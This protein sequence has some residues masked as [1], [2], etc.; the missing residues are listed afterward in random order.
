MKKTKHLLALILMLTVLLSGC[1]LFGSEPTQ[2]AQPQTSTSTEPTVTEPA[3]TES[4]PTELTPAETEPAEPEPTEPEGELFSVTREGHYIFEE[5]SYD[6]GCVQG[7]PTGVFTIVDRAQDDE[8]L[9]WGK[10]KS[11]M[12]W[13][14]LTE[15]EQA[16]Q[17]ALPVA[18]VEAYP[19]LLKG[20]NADS[21]ELF[22]EEYCYKMAFFAYEKLTDVKLS[23]IDIIS[24]E[25]A[26]KEL[27]WERENLTP[28]RPVMLHLTFPGN[29]TTY[30]LSFLDESGEAR[31]FHIMQ[32]GRNGL[33]YT[34]EVVE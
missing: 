8:G 24:E 16:K 33:I 22:P 18:M 32:S 31:I 4:A 2:P 10:L 19:E 29:F 5:P 14:C 17:A 15:I 13:I 21:Y 28:E 6:G 11:G 34:W 27:K 12:G 3:P 30:E 23:I 25:P 9:D 26:A 1:S 7:M 20:D